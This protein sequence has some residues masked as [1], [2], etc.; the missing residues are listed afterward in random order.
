MY[1]KILGIL[2]GIY[3]DEKKSSPQQ[4]CKVQNRILSHTHCYERTLVYITKFPHRSQSWLQFK[5]KE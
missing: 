1:L 2:I 3:D 5:N 4:I